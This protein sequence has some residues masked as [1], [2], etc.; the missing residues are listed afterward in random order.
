MHI[1][2]HSSPFGWHKHARPWWR[3]AR[4]LRAVRWERDSHQSWDGWG[5]DPS[6]G[7][8]PHKGRKTRRAVSPWISTTCGSGAAAAPQV[9]DSQ[10]LTQSKL[11]LKKIKKKGW[12]SQIFCHTDSM[13]N[14][15][16]QDV[17]DHLTQASYNE[18]RKLYPAIPAKNWG[19]IYG[20][21]KVDLLEK[22]FQNRLTLAQK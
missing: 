9:L 5:K 10:R 15:E 21:K 3:L 1:L 2:R 19:A 6:W 14:K 16:I 18:Q 12:L 20:R 8:R 17:I 4:I 13:E 7:L 22:N 11:F